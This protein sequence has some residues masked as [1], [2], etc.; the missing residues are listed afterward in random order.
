MA[1][2]ELSWQDV[3]SEKICAQS[4]QAT[5]RLK[6]RIRYIRYVLKINFEINGRPVSPSNLEDALEG[7]I[8][9]QIG[10]TIHSKLTGIRDPETGEFPTVAIRGSLDNLSF[11]VSGSPR[12]VEIVKRR[13]G[14]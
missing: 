4:S 14:N 8:L 7:A 13:L 9:E 3:R 10:R 12:L 6:R 2:R 5:I 1:S 11:L